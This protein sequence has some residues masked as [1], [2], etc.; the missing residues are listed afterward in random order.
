MLHLVT[1]SNV[2]RNIKSAL[3]PRSYAPT[4]LVMARK[5]YKNYV[6]RKTGKARKPSSKYKEMQKRISILCQNKEWLAKYEVMPENKGNFDESGSQKQMKLT[7]ISSIVKSFAHSVHTL[8]LEELEIKK[9]DDI[10]NLDRIL[11]VQYEMTQNMYRNMF[12]QGEFEE[13]KMPHLLTHAQ[14]ETLTALC[15]PYYREP[16]VIKSREEQT[17]INDPNRSLFKT[18]E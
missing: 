5:M 1:L 14:E 2:T 12:T 10:S 8:E 11:Q 15:R 3:E 6:S 4:A 18:E 13:I 17:E 7:L 16:V 9:A